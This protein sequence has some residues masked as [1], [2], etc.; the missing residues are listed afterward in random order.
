MGD[1]IGKAP[2]IVNESILTY[3][4]SVPLYERVMIKP[5]LI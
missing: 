2:I 4:Q 3:Y 5:V 1:N